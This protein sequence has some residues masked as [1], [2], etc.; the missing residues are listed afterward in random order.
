MAFENI[1]KDEALQ[2]FDIAVIDNKEYQ[3]QTIYQETF[4]E[5]SDKKIRISYFIFIL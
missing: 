5:L 4:K 1:E 2:V 3:N